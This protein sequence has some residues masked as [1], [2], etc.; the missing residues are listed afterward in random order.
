MRHGGAI[1][2]R[3]MSDFKVGD[4][5]VAVKDGVGFGEGGTLFKKG[6]TGTIVEIDGNIPNIQFDQGA[7]G[8]YCGGLWWASRDKIKLIKP[9]KASAQ[10]EVRRRMEKIRKHLAEIEDLIAEDE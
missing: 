3:K 1:Q 8:F 4:R 7:D 6:D 2:E 9:R 5:V 10:D